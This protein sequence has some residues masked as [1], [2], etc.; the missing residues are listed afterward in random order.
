MG[1]NLKFP[2]ASISAGHAHITDVSLD[3]PRE[4]SELKGLKTGAQ[5]KGLKATERAGYSHL[6]PSCCSLAIALCLDFKFH[7]WAPPGIFS[8]VA[9]EEDSTLP[10]LVRIQLLRLTLYSCYMQNNIPAICRLCCSRQISNPRQGTGANCHGSVERVTTGY[11]MW[12]EE[13]CKKVSRRG[14]LEAEPQGEWTLVGVQGEDAGR[15]HSEDVTLL[16]SSRIQGMDYFLFCLCHSTKK[17][18]MQEAVGN[19]SLSLCYATVRVF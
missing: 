13:G 3:L 1:E 19:S 11:C 18:G 16:G 2:Q 7:M 10:H 12:S 17:D 9:R 4:L 6:G 8:S 5:T 15:C 14:D